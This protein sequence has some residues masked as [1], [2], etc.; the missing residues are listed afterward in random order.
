MLYKPYTK[1]KP[2]SDVNAEQSKAK[3]RREI[4]R[5]RETKSRLA[6]S[7]SLDPAIPKDISKPV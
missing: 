2:E 6:S 3:T 1:S 7:E 5:E 4:V